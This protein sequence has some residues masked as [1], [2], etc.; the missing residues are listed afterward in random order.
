MEWNCIGL[1]VREW[2]VSTGR[3]RLTS[4]HNQGLGSNSSG[5]VGSSGNLVVAKGI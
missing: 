5:P 1:I 2:K 4:G 3:N